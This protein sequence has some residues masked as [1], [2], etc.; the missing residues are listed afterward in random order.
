MP[1]KSAMQYFA[2]GLLAAVFAAPVARG[3]GLEKSLEVVSGTN[4]SAVHSQRKIDDLARETRILLEEYQSLKESAEYQ[5]AYSRE[6]QQLNEAQQAQIESLNRQIAQARVTRQRI[7]PLMR[8]MADALEQFVVLDLPFHQEQRLGAVL[9]LK[10]R[11]D[12]PDLSVSARFRMLLEV[13][14]LEQDYSSTVEAW[15]D[16]LEVDGESR[17]VEFLRIGR[18][19]LYYQTLDRQASAY[20]DVTE[21]KWQSLPEGHN[22][23]LS[24]ALRVARKEVAPQLLELPV[25]GA[26]G[27]L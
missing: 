13:Y 12:R 9:Q 18:S 25:A 26:G 20:W 2:I 14:Q 4:S 27:A 5:S 3:Q 15:R 21:R 16:V 8:S 7:L 22:R 11:L 17:S 6:L 19:L 24:R 10:Q 23:G 1:M